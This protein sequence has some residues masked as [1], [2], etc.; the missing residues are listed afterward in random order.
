MPPHD[1]VAL[2]DS[3]VGI[4]AA[5]AAGFRVIAVPNHVFYPD[6]EALALADIVIGSVSRLEE[7]LNKLALG[8]V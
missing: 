8:N 1:C 3:G 7:A 5:S 6:A 4:R 2:E